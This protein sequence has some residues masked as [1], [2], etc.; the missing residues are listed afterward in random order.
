[1]DRERLW[2]AVADLSWHEAVDFKLGELLCGAEDAGEHIR[3][4]RSVA[5]EGEVLER[6]TVHG[7]E[8]RELDVGKVELEGLE[9][10]KG[11]EDSRVALHTVSSVSGE[12]LHALQAGS[13]W[14][15]GLRL[16]RHDAH[17]V[18]AA[19]HL[20]HEHGRLDILSEVRVAL[21]EVAN[22]AVRVL[23]KCDL[24]EAERR[25][26][27]RVGEPSASVVAD[28]TH[29]VIK[30]AADAAHAEQL[31]YALYKQCEGAMRSSL[32][33]DEASKETI[34]DWRSKTRSSRDFWRFCQH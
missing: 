22:L 2:K 28:L 18:H 34:C 19:V 9:V 29:Q 16:D 5:V 32:R 15:A 24:L 12:K 25:R 1:M 10:L 33:T 27:F 14:L 6:L 11:L 31:L 17:A 26:L 30:L 7:Y 8:R 13:P 3:R 21:N 20:A 23:R 4:E